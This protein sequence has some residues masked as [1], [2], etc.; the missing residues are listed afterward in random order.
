MFRKGFKV[1]CFYASLPHG[2]ATQGKIVEFWF[3]KL[4]FPSVGSLINN[5]IFMLQCLPN[6][7]NT[8][9]AKEQPVARIGK[10]WVIF[11][12]E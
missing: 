7:E 2:Q 8:S 5:I 9:Y 11:W 12:S 4:G 3:A 10:V 1:F 6:E